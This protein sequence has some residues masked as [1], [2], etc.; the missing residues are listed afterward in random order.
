M[1]DLVRMPLDGDGS[2]LIRIGPYKDEERY[3]EPMVGTG[4][5][6]A[7][8]VVDRVEEV[9]AVA[10]RSLR[11]ALEPVT[12]MSRQILEQL[13]Q[14]RP[15]EVKVEFGVELTAQAGAVLATAGTACHL[16]VTLTWGPDDGPASPSA[17]RPGAG[18]NDGQDGT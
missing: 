6:R 13:G 7:G 10:S 4:P 1:S 14:V 15:S 11:E 16:T 9:V 12:E 3:E 18:G 17:G 2:I 8:R 5:V